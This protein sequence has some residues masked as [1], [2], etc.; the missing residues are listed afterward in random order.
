MCDGDKSLSYTCS[1]AAFNQSKYQ[2]PI[3]LAVKCELR[4]GRSIEAPRRKVMRYFEGNKEVVW[5]I[6]TRC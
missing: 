4:M 2:D 3:Y 6:M 1:S 5:R